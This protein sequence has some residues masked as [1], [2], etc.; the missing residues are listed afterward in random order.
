MP[1]EVEEQQHEHCDS[2][3]PAKE[4]KFIVFE[5]FFDQLFESCQKCGSQSSISKNTAGTYVQITIVCH[6]CCYTRKWASQPASNSMPLG[7]LIMAGAILFS[8]SSASKFLT[9]CGHASLQMFSI[10]TYMNIQSLYLVPTIEDVWQRQQCDLFNAA[11]ANGEPLRLGGDGRCCS[12]GHTAKYLSYTLMD[13]RTNKIMDTQLVQ[14][15]ILL[16]STI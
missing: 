15:K 11:R 9:L 1:D 13:L 10:G 2:I 6:N 12:P 16:Y 4:R 7:N 8:G 14:V 5:T 3:N